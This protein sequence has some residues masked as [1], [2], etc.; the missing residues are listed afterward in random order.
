MGKIK[1]QACIAYLEGM[2]EEIRDFDS[3]NSD[4]AEFIAHIKEMVNIVFEHTAGDHL[5]NNPECIVED[6]MKQTTKVLAISINGDDLRDI[7]RS[8]EKMFAK[9]DF[10][11]MA[12]A[13]TALDPERDA[14]VTVD[15]LKVE[16]RKCYLE[17]INSLGPVNNDGFIN[18]DLL[19]SPSAECGILGF[20]LKLE[21]NA[22]KELWVWTLN[23]EVSSLYVYVNSL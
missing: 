8:F 22:D 20:M 10:Q 16:I 11:K 19:D 9:I 3:S 4:P 7:S 23:L 21:F 6:D 12:D 18:I 1:R 2:A 13:M 15:G 5:Y 14:K 17:V